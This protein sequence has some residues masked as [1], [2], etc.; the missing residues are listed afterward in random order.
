L[1][2]K[3]L[4]I[5]GHPDSGGDHFCHLL[6]EHYEKNAKQA[7]HKVKKIDV[8][9][10]NFSLLKSKHEYEKESPEEDILKSQEL[11]NWANHLVFIFPLWL[12]GMPALLKGF[13]EQL[14]RPGFA[15]EI[16]DNGIWKR[17]LKGKSAR[18]IVTMGMPAM[19]YRWFF[20][21]HSLKNLE[22]NILNF[23]G[24]KPVRNTLIGLV[25]NMNDSRR[26][27]ILAKVASLAHKGM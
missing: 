2:R 21:A 8:G 20:F 10:L 27:K 19:A 3:I 11:V 16:L 23:V 25:E 7:G 14:A 17:K 5:Q 9:H 18:V 6:E 15:V 13:L 24:I 26:E 22:R 4:I 1:S 12:G